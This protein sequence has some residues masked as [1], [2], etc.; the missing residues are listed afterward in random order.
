MESIKGCESLCYRERHARESN[1]STSKMLALANLIATLLRLQPPQIKILHFGTC[2][3]RSSEK[4]KT[5][6]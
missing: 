3:R 6:F 5:G 2:P 1:N 4:F